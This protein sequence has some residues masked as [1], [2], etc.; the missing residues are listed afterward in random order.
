MTIMSHECPIGAKTIGINS[1]TN[2]LKFYSRKKYSM[3]IKE[4]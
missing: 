4:K 3:N 1:C 2:K